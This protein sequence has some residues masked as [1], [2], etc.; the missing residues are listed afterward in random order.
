MA[1]QIATPPLLK[2]HMSLIELQTGWEEM[3]R[4]TLEGGGV[5]LHILSSFYPATYH[6]NGIHHLLGGSGVP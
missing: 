1:E 6:L 5:P 2:L 3:C 4:E